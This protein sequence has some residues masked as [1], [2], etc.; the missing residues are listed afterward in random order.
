MLRSVANSPGLVISGLVVLLVLG[1]AFAPSLFAAQDPLAINLTERLRP[2]GGEHVFGTDQLGRDMYS[3]IVYGASLSMRTTILSVVLATACGAVVGAV[4]GFVGGFLDRVLMRLVD[5]L[6]AVPSMLLSLGVVTVLGFGGTNIAIAVGVAMVV[7]LARVM[8][9]EVLRVC[10]S[11]YVEAAWVSGMRMPGVLARHVV[12][13]AAG[14][15]LVLA[16]LE[17]GAVM[18]QISALSFLGFGAPPPTPEWGSLVADGRDYLISGWWLSALPGLTIAAV[19]L[20]VNRTAQA[21][22][23]TRGTSG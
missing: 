2:P 10:G 12:P 18:L 3:R 9:A 16:V 15:V 17:F 6:L 20:S 22:E 5:V 13:N 4:A 8:R 19:V 14:P 23:R 11:T 7:R 21:L 1:W